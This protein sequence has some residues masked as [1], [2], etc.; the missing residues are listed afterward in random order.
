MRQRMFLPIYFLILLFDLSKGVDEK[1]SLY[2]YAGCV[3]SGM[4]D[5][6]FNMGYDNTPIKDDFKGTI[7]TFQTKDV[8]GVEISGT[9]YFNA[10]LESDT[11]RIFTTDEYKNVEP[12]IGY[13]PFPEIKFQLDLQCIKGNISLRFVQPLTDVNNH[14]PYFEKEI[15]EYIYVQNSLPSNHQ[16]T[17][18]QSLS[19]F[20]IDMTNN[21]LS[22]S[23]EE[24]DYFSIDTAST[25]STTRQT[26][27]TLTSLKDIEAPS[28]IKLNLSATVSIC[29]I[30]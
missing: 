29:L 26:F 6:D 27:T 21:R 30:L 2:N 17:D 12:E 20:D 24:N 28:T 23:I 18:N 15:Y 8:Y 10:T 19:A 7:A 14:D 3:I 1:P 13:D 25:D 16:L 5:A 22:F 11:L 4:Q 9:N